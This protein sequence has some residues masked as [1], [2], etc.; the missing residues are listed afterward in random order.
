MHLIEI[1]IAIDMHVDVSMH[2]EGDMCVEER[3]MMCQFIEREGGREGGRGAF[4]RHDH[5]CSRIGQQQG[6]LLRYEQYRAHAC[7]RVPE[8]TDVHADWQLV[9]YVYR[10]RARPVCR[11]IYV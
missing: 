10:K 9:S 5:A 8:R 2:R 7:K 6:N 3:N 11:C 4:C 1:S